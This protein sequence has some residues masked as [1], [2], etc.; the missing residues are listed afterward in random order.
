MSST[1]QTINYLTK[2]LE[3]VV[4][5]F[6][7]CIFLLTVILVALRYGFNS[8]IIGANEVMNYLFIYTTA[9][10][11]AISLGK[12]T[13]IRISFFVDMLPEKI[14]RIVTILNYILIGGFNIILTVYSINWIE[15]TGGFES[16]VLRIPKWIVQISIP[17]GCILATIYCLNHVVILFFKNGNNKTTG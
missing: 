15:S 11:A 13:H 17:I 5:F 4:S 9:L 7:V 12:N 2:I 1:R 16:P 10:G 6:F 14:N 8:S 3:I